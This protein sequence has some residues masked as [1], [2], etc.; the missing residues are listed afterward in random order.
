MERQ[1]HARCG[2]ERGNA[3]ESFFAKGDAVTV[4]ALVDDGHFDNQAEAT[5]VIADT[6]ATLAAS[7]PTTVD[8]GDS[9]SFQI[10]A[11][12]PDPADAPPSLSLDY[13]PAGMVMDDDGVITWT[14]RAPLF[15]R[16]MDFNWRAAASGD[17]PG[18]LSGTIIVND[19]DR[20][21]PL[22]RFGVEIPTEAGAL[23]VADLD[24]DGDEEIL[25][26]SFK[27][28]FEL[29]KSGAAYV[30][31]WAHPFGDGSRDVSAV[32]AKDIGGDG[33]AEIFF[34]ADDTITR[35][36][37]VSRRQAAVYSS[38]TPFFC[39]DI[40]I[41]DLTG[42]GDEELVC[43]GSNVD[44]PFEDEGRIVV[45]DAETLEPLWESPE[46]Q[47]G[48]TVAIGNVD[49]DAA[50]EI[51]ACGGLVFDGATLTNQWS[52]SEAFGQVVATGDLDNDGVEEIVGMNG[53]AALRGF[54]ATLKSP[55]W[56]LQ[57]SDLDALHVGNIDGDPAAEVIV[58]DGQWGNVTAYDYVTATNSLNE[59]WHIQNPDHGVT[60]IATGDVDNDGKIE[61]VWGSGATSSGADVFAVAG[62]NPTIELEWR[63]DN[64]VQLD[65]GFFGA[66]L[67]TVAPGQ[68]R[69]LFETPSTDSGY[70][71]ARLVSLDPQSGSLRVSPELGSNWSNAGAL[72]RRGLRR[73][74]RRRGLYRY[75]GALRPVLRC[76]R[77]R[78]WN[79]R[80]V[81][82]AGR[83]RQPRGRGRIGRPDRRRCRR[84]DRDDDRRSG[85]GLRRA[86]SDAPLEERRQRWRRRRRSDRSR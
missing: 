72:N 11:T 46:L 20:E 22:R 56:D 69:V 61:I 52:Y 58:G 83:L 44:S 37:G 14:A 42:D 12:D 63:N 76:R 33:K 31:V 68:R 28:I 39:W 47:V 1:R 60:S 53:G 30:Q 54:N 5:V 45:L 75:G 59:A 3:P 26:G 43:V 48:R 24:G 25:I 41:A 65:G 15:D 50:L 40:A 32:V 70:E 71:G 2:A 51:V 7:A 21:L 57:S 49:A 82:A 29:A 16:A 38:D 80:V 4:I 84:S 85:R 62:L 6:P 35:L 34:A 66:R 10:T 27:G 67:A 55:I 19:A 36:D 17:A 13:G 81:F 77:F 9:V 23:A 64:P 74:R 78:G 8:Y 73:R 79:R 18:A 86:A